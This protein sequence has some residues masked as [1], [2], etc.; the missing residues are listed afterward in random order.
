M[1][2][3]LE[4]PGFEKYPNNMPTVENMYKKFI[5]VATRSNAFNVINHG[6]LWCNNILFRYQE[7]EVTDAVFVDRQ[8]SSNG[9]LF[10]DLPFFFSSNIK[11]QNKVEEID[12]LLIYYLAELLSNLKKFNIKELPCREELLKD[13]KECA[14]IGRSLQ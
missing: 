8:L 14:I 7:N 9:T 2:V 4:L 10:I 1:R 5:A 11:S 12:T 13:F 6:D 3:L